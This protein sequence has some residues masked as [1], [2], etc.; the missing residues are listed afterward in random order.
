MNVV[1]TE[2]KKEERK[3][4]FK[5]EV[6]KELDV[7]MKEVEEKTTYNIETKEVNQQAENNKEIS[8]KL[9]LDVTVTKETQKV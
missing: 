8:D 3:V 2:Q 1:V 6:I 4:A 5:N 7:I 9:S